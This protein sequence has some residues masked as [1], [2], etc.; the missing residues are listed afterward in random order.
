MAKKK[1]NLYGKVIEYTR[2]ENGTS[3]GRRPKTSSMNKNK[4]RMRGKHNYRGQGKWI[5]D[6]AFILM[7]SLYLIKCHRILDH[8]LVEVVVGTAD[9]ILI[10]T[11]F[12]DSIVPEEL[13]ILMF[14]I[15]G[16]NDTS[17]DRYFSKSL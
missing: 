3:I 11:H 2:T 13:K 14:V 9:F 10:E 4:R 17:K 1:G 16:E 15:N 8:H 12:V 7:V 5:R 6:Q